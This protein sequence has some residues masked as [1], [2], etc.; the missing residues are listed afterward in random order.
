MLSSIKTLERYC[1]ATLNLFLIKKFD[2]EKNVCLH[3]GFFM[4]N[5]NFTAEHVEIVKNSRFFQFF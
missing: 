3:D 1:K 2:D 5:R 4:S